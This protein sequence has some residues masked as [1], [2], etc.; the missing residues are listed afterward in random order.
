MGAMAS[1]I[2]RLT[3]VYST[4]YL[5]GDQ[6]KYQRSVP[7]AFL[8]GIHRWP[9]NSPHKC[10]VK[11][12]MFPFHYVIIYACVTGSCTHFRN[13]VPNVWHNMFDNAG[14]IKL[15]N[16]MWKDT[17]LQHIINVTNL[18]SDQWNSYIIYGQNWIR[19]SQTKQHGYWK[20]C[21]SSERCTLC[22]L[23]ILL[24]NS[25]RYLSR[26]SLQVVA[27]NNNCMEQLLESVYTKEH[28]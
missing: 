11:R 24:C 7:L 12:K 18:S 22:L 1:Q 17:Y 5:G 9:V 28:T 26:Q 14:G 25:T 8:R 13:V 4:V 16:K 19:N 10:P 27:N 6:R 21:F 15:V 23:L 2:T 3:I 20:Y